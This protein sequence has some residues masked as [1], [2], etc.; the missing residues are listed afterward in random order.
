M[1]QRIAI[2]TSIALLA[3]APL[4]FA[5]GPGRERGP[6]RGGS[7]FERGE[8]HHPG[9]GG[10]GMRELRHLLPPPGYLDLSEEQKEAVH[11]L[12]EGLR[13]ELEPLREQGKAL[14][15]QL[16]DALESESPNAATVGQ[17]MIDL[18][19]LKDQ[20]RQIFPAYEERFASLL[21]PDQ[22]SK[23]QTFRE[24][25]ELRRGHRRGPDGPGGPDGEEMP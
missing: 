6:F 9:P 16:H 8:G 14:R 12:F 24:L 3:L 11:E 20:K 5:Q 10:R 22:L 2:W 1:K 19:A 15:E 21:T 17:L 7:G 13:S 23:W 4:V 18:H 25:R